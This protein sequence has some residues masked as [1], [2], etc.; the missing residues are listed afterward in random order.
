MKVECKICKKHTC[1]KC[2][3]KWETDHEGKT[4]EELEVYNMSNGVD[5]ISNQVKKY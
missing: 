2:K 1:F 5:L 3:E 4:C